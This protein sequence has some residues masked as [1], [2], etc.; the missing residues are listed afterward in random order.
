MGGYQKQPL[1]PNPSHIYDQTRGMGNGNMGY[2]GLNQD[3]LV[4]QV[5]AVVQRLVGNNSRKSQ[6]QIG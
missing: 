3:P 2:P 5:E 4:A 1:S 6:R